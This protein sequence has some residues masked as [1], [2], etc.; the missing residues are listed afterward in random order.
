MTSQPTRRQEVEAITGKSAAFYSTADAIAFAAAERA[1][2]EAAIAYS[3]EGRNLSKAMDLGRKLEDACQAL[4][5]LRAA[6]D[7]KGGNLPNDP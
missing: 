6:Q 5:R 7:G 1:V 2:V 3:Q 4:L